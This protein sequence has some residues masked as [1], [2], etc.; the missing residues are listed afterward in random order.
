MTQ[1]IDVQEAARIVTDMHQFHYRAWDK[2]DAV[3]RMARRLKDKNNSDKAGPLKE[4]DEVKTFFKEDVGPHFQME[5]ARIY[6]LVKSLLPPRQ[7]ISI[8]YM[9]KEHRTI[10]QHVMQL[11]GLTQAAPESGTVV[12][13]EQAEAVSEAAL[14]L[15][16]LMRRH[17]TK[18]NVIY[19][20]LEAVA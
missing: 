1:S 5:E 12:P 17:I 15:V 14:Q 4:I 6:P 7:R 10:W 11:R 16:R 13:V 18:E 3:E 8:A 9:V 20:T 2:M 19:Q